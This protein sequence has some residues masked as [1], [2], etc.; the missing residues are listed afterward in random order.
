MIGTDNG[1]VTT[2]WLDSDFQI[3]NGRLEDE[4]ISGEKQVERPRCPD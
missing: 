4:E 3:V 2:A 1:P